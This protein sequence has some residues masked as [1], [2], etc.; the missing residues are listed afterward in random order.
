MSVALDSFDRAP[1][2]I[3][4]GALFALYLV[5]ELGIGRGRR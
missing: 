2:W 1:W 4:L 5:V 3:V